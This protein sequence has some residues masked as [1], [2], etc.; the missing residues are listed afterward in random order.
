MVEGIFGEKWKDKEVTYG[1][2]KIKI[3]IFLYFMRNNEKIIE[4]GM[5][6]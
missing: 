5:M 6:E 3:Y 2:K 4:N 1:M